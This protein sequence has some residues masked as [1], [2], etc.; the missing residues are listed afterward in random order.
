MTILSNARKEAQSK[1]V[2]FWV[3]SNSKG[4]RAYRQKGNC[5]PKKRTYAVITWIVDGDDGK[6]Y[7]LELSG[8]RFFT[9]IESNLRYQAGDDAV[10]HH[11]NPRYKELLALVG[12]KRGLDIR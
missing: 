7:I 8:Y 2:K 6:I 4:E 1:D 12:E 9:I 11:N 5:K 10:I 3:E